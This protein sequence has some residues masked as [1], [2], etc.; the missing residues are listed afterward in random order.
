MLLQF[1]AEPISLIFFFYS[2]DIYYFLEIK[3]NSEIKTEINFQL[4]RV[5]QKCNCR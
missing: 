3:C 1:F 2:D 5:W 4:T